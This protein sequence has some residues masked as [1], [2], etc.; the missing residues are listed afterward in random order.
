MI[1]T[2]TFKWQ[3]PDST[4]A[5]PTTAFTKWVDVRQETGCKPDGTITHLVD[6]TFATTR[7]HFIKNIE[8]VKNS[9]IVQNL[10]IKL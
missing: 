10:Y 4:T 9:K 1:Y 6:P 3:A 8:L 5:P 7:A 2:S